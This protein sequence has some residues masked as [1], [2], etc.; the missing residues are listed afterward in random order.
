MERKCIRCLIRDPR[1]HAPFNP[2]FWIR[3]PGRYTR[4]VLDL[5]SACSRPRG[6][7]WENCN[8][9]DL[10]GPR[11]C[12]DNKPSWCRFPCRRESTHHLPIVPALDVIFGLLLELIARIERQIVWCCDSWCH[13]RISPRCR[14]LISLRRDGYHPMTRKQLS[15]TLHPLMQYDVCGVHVTYSGWHRTCNRLQVRVPAARLHERPWASCSQT[16]VS[17]H[18]AV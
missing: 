2:Y 13:Y 9:P 1:L 16:R 10:T 11:Q 15:S 7:S 12:G 8:G 6:K 14:L 17:V 4:C 5:A 18:K 3:A